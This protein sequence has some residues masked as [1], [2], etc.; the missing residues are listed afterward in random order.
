MADLPS[1]PVLVPPL[2]P[3][4]STTGTPVISGQS[5][6][7]KALVPLVGLAGVILALPQAGVLIPA[8]WGNVVNA[9]A[10]LVVTLG[11]IFGLAGPGIRKANTSTDAAAVFNSPRPSA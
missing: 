8:P 6:L 1:S 7:L 9:V 3:A 2:A 5:W 4:P 10:T 11:G